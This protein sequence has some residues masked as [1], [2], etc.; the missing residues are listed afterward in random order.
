MLFEVFLS[1]I[2]LPTFFAKINEAKKSRKELVKS[3][4]GMFRKIKI[5]LYD[6]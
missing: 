4:V 1:Y 3:L 6:N 5:S 2:I